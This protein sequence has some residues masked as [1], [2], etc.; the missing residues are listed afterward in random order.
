MIIILIIT[1][2]GKFSECI[3]RR[4]HKQNTK[5]E[6]LIVKKDENVVLMSPKI[7]NNMEDLKS[8]NLEVNIKC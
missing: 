1:A 4:S 7:E 8:I 2:T 6:F 3:K 5:N